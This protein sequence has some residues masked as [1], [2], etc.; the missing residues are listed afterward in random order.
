MV[1][2]MTDVDERDST[3]LIAALAVPHRAKHA[4]WHL[5][6]PSPNEPVDWPIRRRVIVRD[7]FGTPS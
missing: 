6:R 4:Y 5:R 2:P 3:P 7:A 1:L